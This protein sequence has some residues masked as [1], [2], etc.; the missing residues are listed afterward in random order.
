MPLPASGSPISLS[1]LQTEFGGSDPIKMSEYYR[2][3]GLTTNNN[4]DVPTSGPIELGDFAGGGKARQVLIELIGGGGGGGGG[5]DDGAGSGYAGSG[6]ASRVT[7]SN[8]HDPFDITA[9]GGAGGANGNRTYNSPG[10]G[11]ASYYGPGGYQGFGN[12]NAPV[13]N[14]GAGGGGAYGD[15]PF[16]TFLFLTDPAGNAG[17]GGSASDYQ[18]HTKLLVV[19][20]TVTVLVG[21]GGT[22]GS[23]TER[24]G[25]TGAPGYVKF[26]VGNH[27][28]EYF[29]DTDDTNQS[30]YT[31]TVPS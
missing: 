21:R 8:A 12:R 14:Y 1:Q 5:M 27:V 24:I 23:G 29:Y 4:I 11:E 20:S 28:T 31:F 9:A 16:Y 18:S 2:G 15:S 26:T 19:G 7:Q 13:T 17:S 10:T 25:G 3:G 6:Q 30:S 22:G